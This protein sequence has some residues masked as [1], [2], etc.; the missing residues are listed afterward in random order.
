M[1]QLG[2]IIDFECGKM[3]PASAKRPMFIA[4]HQKG[5]WHSVFSEGKAG[6]SPQLMKQEVWCMDEQLSASPRPEIHHRIIPGMLG[7]R[8]M[9]IAPRCRQIIVGRF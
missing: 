8:R 9:S 6:Y 4:F 5:I 1:D 3:L 2:A 7:L